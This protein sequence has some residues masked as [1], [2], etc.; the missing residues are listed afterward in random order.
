MKYSHQW[1]PLV[2]AV[3]AW[4][5]YAQEAG[6]PAASSPVANDPAASAT[7]APTGAISPDGL[8]IGVDTVDT[9]RAKLGKPLSVAAL[10]NGTTILTYYKAKTHIKGASFIPMVGLFAGGVKSDVVLRTFTFDGKGLL[11]AFSSI[12]SNTDCRTTIVG[13]KCQ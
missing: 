5:A 12:D 6:A 4:A 8:Q 1:F 3:I 11:K 13:A 9:V 2:L 10:S 7:P